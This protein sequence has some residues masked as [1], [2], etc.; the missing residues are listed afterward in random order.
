MLL[1]GRYC[2]LET[3]IMRTTAGNPVPGPAILALL[4]LAASVLACGLPPYFP[5]T[6]PAA[7]LYAAA[8]AGTVCLCCWFTDWRFV[9]YGIVPLLMLWVWHHNSGYPQLPPSLTEHQ[10]IQARSDVRVSGRVV[11]F[12]RVRNGSTRF[13]FRLDDPQNLRGTVR[14]NWY[15]PPDDIQVGSR[16]QLQLRLREPRGLANPGGF[17]YPRA[18]YLSNIFA[19]GY[20]RDSVFNT[21]LNN[22]QA[23][24]VPADSLIDS[25]EDAVLKLRSILAEQIAVRVKP[26]TDALPLLLALSV[27]ARHQLTQHHWQVFRRTGTSHL[28]AISGLHISLAAGL[29][30]LLGRV[31]LWFG[32]TALLPWLMG[33]LL[34]IGYT[35]LSG[36]GLPANRALLMLLL[37]TALMLSRREYTGFDLLGSAALATL[38]LQP[39]AAFQAGFW[40]SFTAVAVLIHASRLFAAANG[41]S[42]RLITVGDGSSRLNWQRIRLRFL[43]LAVLQCVLVLALAVPGAWFF[44]EVSLLAPLVN[45]IAIPL[46]SIFIVPLLLLAIICVVIFPALADLLFGLLSVLL[47]QCFVA[48]EWLA[49]FPVATLSLFAADALVLLS[50][51]LAVLLL[52][53]P[54]AAP[55]RHLAW[56]LLLPAVFGVKPVGS[57]ALQLDMLDVGHGLAVLVRAGE[58]SLLYDTGPSWRGGDAGASVVLPAIR[59]FGSGR[60]DQLIVSH[61]DSDHAGGLASVQQAFPGVGP[62]QCVAGDQWLWTWPEAIGDGVLFTAVHPSAQHRWSDNN[63]SCVLLIEY[64]GQRILLPG[65]IETAAEGVLVA[66]EVPGAV[67]LVVIPHHGSLTSSTAGFVAMLQADYAVASTAWRNHWQFPREAVVRRWNASGSCVLNTADTGALRFLVDEQGLRLE[68]TWRPVRSLLRWPWVG[69]SVVTLCAGL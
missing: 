56:L 59:K 58:K 9:R 60:P 55:G 43:Q 54:H 8:V 16:W 61:S 13:D 45:L 28:L 2:R 65:D 32:C 1:V 50:A 46:F 29:G 25:F 44:G 52:L 57:P 4:S 30:V 68:R 38:I 21:P 41:P 67:D 48:L 66:A 20:V 24:K 33:A 22:L 15:S 11:S 31:F 23:Q 12:P 53:A 37:F 49:A 34:G 6:T 7:S 51:L 17:D 19:V 69:N 42:G 47:Q 64:A 5:L 27:G 3:C 40:L 63:G 36:F 18:M 26:G 35:V 14:L 62:M 39:L 10:G